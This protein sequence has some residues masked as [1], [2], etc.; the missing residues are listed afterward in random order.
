MQRVGKTQYKDVRLEN[1]S[2]FVM[3][4]GDKRGVVFLIDHTD[5][6]LGNSFYYIPKIDLIELD[7]KK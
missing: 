4:A 2:A 6:E 7:F 3:L 1:G 5:Q